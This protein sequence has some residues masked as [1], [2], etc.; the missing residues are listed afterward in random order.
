M[1]INYRKLFDQVEKPGR[2]IGK[3]LNSVIKNLDDIDVRYV[4][5]FPDLYE[6]GM[7]H[8]G[9]HIL[10]GVLNS[11]DKVWCERVFSVASDLEEQLRNNNI[12]LF[13]I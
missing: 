8:L 5:A 7:S 1:S 6:I 3:E 10:Y 13:S 9:M 12:P 2:Y 11:D 4:F